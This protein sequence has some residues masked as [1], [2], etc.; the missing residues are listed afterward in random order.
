MACSDLKRH[1][2]S[3][4]QMKMFGFGKLTRY[5]HRYNLVRENKDLCPLGEDSKAHYV[6]VP[7]ST[8]NLD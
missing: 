2:H 3:D 4:T 5:N 1:C 8:V 6:S 7:P